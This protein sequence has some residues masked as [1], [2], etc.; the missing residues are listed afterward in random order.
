MWRSRPWQGAGRGPLGR[1]TVSL[2]CLCPTNLPCSHFSA[3]LSPFRPCAHPT[4]QASSPS[5]DAAGRSPTAPR[6]SCRGGPVSDGGDV[7]CAT[8][9]KGERSDAIYVMGKAR[10]RRDAASRRNALLYL[11]FTPPSSHLAPSCPLAAPTDATAALSV[12]PLLR[13]PFPALLCPAAF[14]A[15]KCASTLDA[16]PAVHLRPLGNPLTIRPR[17]ASRVRGV[18]FVTSDQRPHPLPLGALHTP[19]FY[20]SRPSRPLRRVRASLRMW[21]DTHLSACLRPRCVATAWAPERCAL[22]RRCFPLCDGHPFILLLCF[23]FPPLSSS[24]CIRRPG[25]ATVNRTFDFCASLPLSLCSRLVF[26]RAQ[27]DRR[28]WV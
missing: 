28:R 23:S 2:A 14:S 19:P 13:A 22:L 5:Q 17:L 4:F 1:S 15:V 6:M 12:N 8:R 18:S 3:D 26:G 9:S 27:G 25:L 16:F 21:R 10:K 11:C 20:R 7:L 24:C